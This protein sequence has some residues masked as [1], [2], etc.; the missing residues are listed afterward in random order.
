[1]EKAFAKQVFGTYCKPVETK[2]P[3]HNTRCRA[4]D[5]FVA[6]KIGICGASSRYIV[7]FHLNVPFEYDICRWRHM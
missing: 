4:R 6:S 3:Q 7:L 1:M 5:I 2:L